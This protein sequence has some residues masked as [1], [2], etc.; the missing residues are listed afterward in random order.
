MEQDRMRYAAKHG[1][2]AMEPQRVP[3]AL[4][5]GRSMKI[6]CRCVTKLEVA[7]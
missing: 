6:N 5:G 2:M 1:Y 7:E 4:A 3:T